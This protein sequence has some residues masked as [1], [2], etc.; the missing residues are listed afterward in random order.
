[1]VTSGKDKVSNQ[2]LVTV[3]N[4]VAAKFFWFF[5]FSNKLG[6]SHS[7]EITPHRLGC[8]CEMGFIWEGGKDETYPNHYGEET[9]I[10]YDGFTFSFVHF[11]AYLDGNSPSI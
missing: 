9:A 2:T 1:M 3:N 5:M 8:Y 4:K 11:P 7:T 10:L 6:R